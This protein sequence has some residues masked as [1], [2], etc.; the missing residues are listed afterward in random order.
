M[1]IVGLVILVLV[2]IAI[3]SV[4]SSRKYSSYGLGRATISV[5]APLQKVATRLS[6]FAK[7][8]WSNYFYLISVAEENQELKS[9]VKRLVEKNNQCLET[10][11]TNSRFRKLLDLR[12]SVSRDIAVAEVIGKDPSQW[13]KTIIIDKGSSEGIKKGL[14][15]IVSG[16]IAGQVSEVSSHYS[17]VLLII[18]RNSAVDALVQRNR[19]RGVIK[20]ASAGECQLDYVL[21]KHDI[22]PGDTVISSGVDGV[23]PKGLRVGYVSDVTKPDFGIF[24]KINVLP[25]VD[26]EKIEEVMVILNPDKKGLLSGLRP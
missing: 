3:L 11:I 10:E 26:F 6:H 13:F 20:G 21:R 17:K 12:A 19:S 9:A 15:V 24:Q 5:I 8:V 4:N 16:D 2:N 23:F 25:Y 7:S 18:D 14:P 1:M 22:K